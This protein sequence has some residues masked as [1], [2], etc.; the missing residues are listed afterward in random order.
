MAGFQNL[1]ETIMEQRGRKSFASQQVGN[2]VHLGG[3]WPQA[4]EG[5]TDTQKANWDAIVHTKP[6]DWFGPDTYPLLIE[7]VRAIDSADVIATAL[8]G[9]NPEW[10]SDPEGLKRFDQLTRLQDAKATSLA[11]LAT[12]M[13][14]SQQSR[15]TE[16]TA[17][18]A[19]KQAS[20]GRKPWES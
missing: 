2:V 8:N 9:F 17:G 18:T 7:Y 3:Q 13:R 14:L 20:A 10:M 1:I 15:Y 4:P 19:A 6:S 16:K 11:R 12:K 5:L